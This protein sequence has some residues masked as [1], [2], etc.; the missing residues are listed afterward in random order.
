MGMSVDRIHA[1]PLEAESLIDALETKLATVSAERDSFNI[2]ARGYLTKLGVAVALLDQVVL[3]L[4]PFAAI[5]ERYPKLADDYPLWA[6]RLSNGEK[7]SN[8]DY[9]QI[10]MKPV[11]KIG[12]LRLARTTLEAIR[13]GKG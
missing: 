7:V 9:S 8:Q 3:A 12:D 5:S 10:E 13:K 6:A 1:K 2:E 11:V 4:E